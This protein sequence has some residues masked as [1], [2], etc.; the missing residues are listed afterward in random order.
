MQL[1]DD[2]LATLHGSSSG[3]VTSSSRG[4]VEVTYNEVERVDKILYDKEGQEVPFILL[5]LK[6]GRLNKKSA[7]KVAALSTMEAPL[8][9]DTVESSLD[10]KG[11]RAIRSETG[12]WR[13]SVFNIGVERA[14]RFSYFGISTNLITYLTGLLQQPTVTA[15]VNVN[16]WSG[17][18]FLLPLFGAFATDGVDFIFRR[19]LFVYICE[20]K[21]QKKWNPSACIHGYSGLETRVIRCSAL[22][23]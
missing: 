13:S 1:E 5:E 20:E 14:E 21:Q 15:A 11:G 2:R 18:G 7:K 22:Y 4:T 16:T 23:W 6:K 8:L 12:R 9:S 10:Y 3:R 17:V 19:G